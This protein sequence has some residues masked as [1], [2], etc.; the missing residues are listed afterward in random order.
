MLMA[1]VPR[2][3]KK[4]EEVDVELKAKQI[5]NTTGCVYYDRCHIPNK[6]AGCARGKPP[7]VEVDHD[8]FVACSYYIKR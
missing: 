1:S 6:D 4:W 5:E 8:H 3:D 7:L 2:L